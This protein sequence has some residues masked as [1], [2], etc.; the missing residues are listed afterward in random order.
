[1]NILL[2]T[3][4][5]LWWITDDAQ[6]SETARKLIKD[7]GNTLYWSAASSWEV[8]IKY[9]LGRLPLPD[10]PEIF[11]AQELAGNQI[12]SLP[13]TDRYAFQAG[14][15]PRHHKDPFDRMLIAQAMTDS[16]ILLSCDSFFGLY[17]VQVMW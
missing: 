4:A 14:R 8:G 13:I 12:E 1:M 10:A 5:F 3:H 6:L 16:L 9:A 7:N 17:D 2:D 15:L 11:L